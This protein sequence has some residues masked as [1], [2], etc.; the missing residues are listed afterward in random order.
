MAELEKTKFIEV[1]DELG[2][3]CTI[4]PN[5]YPEGQPARPEARG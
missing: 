5:I 1:E 4:L 2:K 3:P